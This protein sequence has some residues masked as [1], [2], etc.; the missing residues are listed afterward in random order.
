MDERAAG[1]RVTLLEQAEALGLPLTVVGDGSV[2]GVYVADSLERHDTT[3]NASEATQLLHLAALMHGVFMGPG[4]EIALSSATAGE[5][6]EL[7]HEG[8][9]AALADVARISTIQPK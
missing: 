3:F 2:M 9:R 8:L 4:G 6:L 1:L 7:A 5:A